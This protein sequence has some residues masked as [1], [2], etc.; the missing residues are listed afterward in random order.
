M[1][2]NEY[3]RF[4]HPKLGRFIYQHKG[5]GL[6]IDNIF[7]P[8]NNIKKKTI[9]P[10]TKKIKTQDKLVTNAIERSG[11]LIMKKLHSS[12]KPKKMK[13]IRSF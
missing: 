11:D 3:K 2:S 10:R 4:Y 9:K 13:I 8:K 7:E 5:N 12:S 1:S 6:I